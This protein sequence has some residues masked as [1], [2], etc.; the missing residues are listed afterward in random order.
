MLWQKVSSISTS[1][2]K[3]AEKMKR[4][5]IAL[6]LALSCILLAGCN[7]PQAATLPDKTPAPTQGVGP[8]VPSA[9][10]EKAAQ[11]V[12]T[13][14]YALPQDGSQ[15]L[16]PCKEKFTTTNGQY[17]LLALQKLVEKSTKALPQGL[18]VLGVKAEK[19]LATVNFSQELLSKN[20]GEY[21]QTML[22]YAVVNTLTEDKSIQK[23]QFTVNGKKLD[24]WGQLDM[25]TPFTRNTSYLP[26]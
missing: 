22:L 3:E 7:G 24:V 16:V 25:E 10:A 2:I 9:G 20:Q 11:V 1:K 17:H 8:K 18:K 21:A 13:T 26:K 14:I 15:T 12:E 23:V 5:I 6:A 19:G 4:K